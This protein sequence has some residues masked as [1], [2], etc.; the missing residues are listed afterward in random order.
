MWYG[1][2]FLES[3]DLENGLEVTMTKQLEVNNALAKHALGVLER[4]S[5]INS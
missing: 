3:N 1:R 4:H 5:G 2:V